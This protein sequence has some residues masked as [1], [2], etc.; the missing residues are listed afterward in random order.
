MMM[1]NKPPAPKT[2]KDKA[3]TYISAL[4]D[5]TIIGLLIYTIM[6][7]SCQ[8]C[9]QTGFGANTYTQCK[10]VSDVMKTG[11]PSEVI[12]IY[13]GTQ[14]QEITGNETIEVVDNGK[15]GSPINIGNI[16]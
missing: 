2:K 13:E 12:D 9:Y 5:A 1:D 3:L 7:N 16:K 11:L 6:A 15:L 10:G 14:S 8:I 4:V